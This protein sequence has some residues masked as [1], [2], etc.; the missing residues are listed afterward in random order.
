ML[1]KFIHLEITLRRI[2]C[3][4]ELQSKRRTATL[5]RRLS[6][7]ILRCQRLSRFTVAL[8]LSQ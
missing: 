8:T 2:V 4:Q 5:K 1:K 3:C 6:K 7:A